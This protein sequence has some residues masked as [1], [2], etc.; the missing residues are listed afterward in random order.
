MKGSVGP[1]SEQS[2]SQEINGLDSIQKCLSTDFEALEYILMH[3]LCFSTA[4]LP[5][6]HPTSP[7]PILEPQNPWIDEFYLVQKR[8]LT[9]L[10]APKL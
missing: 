6:P 9:D 5:T 3:A 4:A 7:F 10:K 1:K 8:H 2:Q